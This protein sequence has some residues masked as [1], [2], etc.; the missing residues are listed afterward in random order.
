MAPSAKGSDPS[1]NMIRL[2]ALYRAS[3]EASDLYFS[4][5]C[6]RHKGSTVLDT[7]ASFVTAASGSSIDSD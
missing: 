4:R 3:K 6:E 5:I 2:Q 1:Y 7:R